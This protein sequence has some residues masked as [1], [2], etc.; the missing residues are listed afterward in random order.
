[1]NTYSEDLSLE[2]LTLK[3][4]GLLREKGILGNQSDHRIS[5]TPDQRTIRYYTSLGL[6]QRPRAVGR[7]ARY[8]EIQ[9]QQLLAIKAL[10]AAG[11]PLAEIQKRIYGRSS[12]ELE[13]IVDAVEKMLYRS[14]SEAPEDVSVLRW[15]EVTLVPGLK[16]MVEEQF[17]LDID[18]GELEKKFRAAL[19]ALL[20]GSRKGERRYDHGGKHIEQD[21]HS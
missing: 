17:S 20:S 11:M 10:Q 6:L 5:S 14:E 15:Q 16:L 18:A 7:E 4:D 8:G 19:A 12:K 13:A 2:Q 21:P 1:M 9:V 3:V